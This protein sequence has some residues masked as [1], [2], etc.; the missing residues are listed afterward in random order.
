MER[1]GDVDY[2]GP[3]GVELASLAGQTVAGKWVGEVGW[4]NGLYRVYGTKHDNPTSNIT[5]LN[6]A[7]TMHDGVRQRATAYDGMRQRATACDS[8]QRHTNDGIRR[9]TTACDGPL[10]AAAQVAH[11]SR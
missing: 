10:T 8:V 2:A 9:H 3:L 4:L 7:Y 5:L 11:G 6:I 1:N